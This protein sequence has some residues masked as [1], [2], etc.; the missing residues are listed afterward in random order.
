ML[1][2]HIGYT[3]KTTAAGTTLFKEKIGN[4]EASNATP[5]PPFKK[6]HK[7][8]ID[9][10]LFAISCGREIGAARVL[11]NLKSDFTLPITEVMS[12]DH[13]TS[14]GWCDLCSVL[15]RSIHG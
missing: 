13:Q 2:T 4:T 9:C 11:Q 15:S 5:A 8:M 3:G 1:L 12:T 14:Y 7:L 10:I 6:V